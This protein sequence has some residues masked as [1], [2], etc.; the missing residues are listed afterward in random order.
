M[1]SIISS[2]VWGRDI[3]S[4][5]P[6]PGNVDALTIHWVGS[7]SYNRKK[8]KIA[9][10]IKAIEKSQMRGN[11]SLS[12]V[13]YNFFV[14]KFGRIW[15]GRGFA[16]RNAANGANANNLTSMSVCVLVGQ[17]DSTVTPEILSGLRSLYSE[18]VKHY[19]RSLKVECHSDVR[20]TQCPGPALTALVRSGRIQEADTNPTP[21][22]NAGSYVVKSGDSYWKI[23]Q[24]V[25][26]DGS[27]W[28]EVSDLN[29][30]KPLFPG[31]SIL[32]PSSTPQPAAPA[33]IPVAPKPPTPAPPAPAFPKFPGRSIRI[34]DKGDD[35]RAIQTRL[36]QRGFYSLRI[37]GSFGPMTDISVKNFQRRHARP[38][39][40]VVGP[41]T[42]S[43]LFS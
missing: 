23:S 3:K 41:V 40:G 14:D 36:A 27:R 34:G 9:D 20:A 11:S 26:K 8:D 29:N 22:V 30:G 32:I 31:E 1:T 15:E 39:D 38:M 16:Y 18:A 7:S 25:L 19:G 33:P 42:W 24:E 10:G 4:P 13:S 17:A 2:S 21:S 6:K 12:C 5:P 43:A 35:V 37:D 28:K